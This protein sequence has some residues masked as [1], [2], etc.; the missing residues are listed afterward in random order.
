MSI[1]SADI[2]VNSR[3]EPATLLVVDPPPLSPPLA[4]GGERGK[5]QIP[6]PLSACLSACL[7]CMWANFSKRLPLSAKLGRKIEH[8]ILMVLQGVVL[9]VFSLPFSYF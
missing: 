2:T 8:E 5:R 9:S 7:L 4:M 3:P 1:F 6:P